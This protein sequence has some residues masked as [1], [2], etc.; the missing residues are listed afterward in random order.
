MP[1]A[2]VRFNG[3]IPQLQYVGGTGIQIVTRRI[4]LIRRNLTLLSTCWVALLALSEFQCV[5]M[6][7]ATWHAEMSGSYSCGRTI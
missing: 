4:G 5:Y 3:W 1:A 7:E 2:I 6:F